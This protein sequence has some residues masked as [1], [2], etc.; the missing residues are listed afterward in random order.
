MMKGDM[1]HRRIGG[2]SSASVGRG[3]VLASVYTQ[4]FEVV[5]QTN[6]AAPRTSRSLS[7]AITIY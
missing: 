2:P 6:Y 4:V 7:R 3:D 5:P 1:I